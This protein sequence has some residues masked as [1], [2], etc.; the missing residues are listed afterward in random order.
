MARYGQVVY[1]FFPPLTR[2][3]KTII[4]ITAGVFLV[5]YV[6]GVLPSATLQYYFSLLPLSLFSLR[7]YMVIHRFFI[8]QPFTYLFL[9]GDFGHVFWNLFALWMFGSAL[10]ETWG[11]KKFAQYYFLTGVG[12]GVLDVL[13]RPSST[14]G[15][16][17]CS[18]AIY[19]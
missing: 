14:T 10:E 4:I 1:S 15:V 19:G 13:L 9:H 8:W 6:F 17:G 16:I 11:A 12:A 3:V 5:T 7:P 18:G 2:M